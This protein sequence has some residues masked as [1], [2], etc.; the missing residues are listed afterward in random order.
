MLR[1]RSSREG[2][3]HSSTKQEPGV[4]PRRVYRVAAV[5]VATAALAACSRHFPTGGGYEMVGQPY[6]VNGHRYV[7]RE[8][9]NYSRVGYASWYGADF[10]GH[11]TANGE[12]YDMNRITAAHTTLPLP[13]YVRVTNLENNS[14]IVVRVND[15]GPFH[16]GRIIDLSAHAADLLG[17]KTAGIARVRVEYVGPA[18]LDGNDERML[19]ATYQAPGDRAMRIAYDPDTRTVSATS[20]GIFTRIAQNQN[21]D[22]TP[23]VY[24]PTAI[25]EGED[26]LAGLLGYAGMPALTPAQQ[27]AEAAATGNLPAGSDPVVVQI[28]VFSDLE[29]AHRVVAALRAYGAPMVE[30]VDGAAGPMFSVRLTTTAD[31]AQ[32]SIDA[33]A[34]VG[35]D[36]AYVV[37]G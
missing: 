5:L 15:R 23:P 19:M 16:D 37:P 20:G 31:Q 33:A 12:I 29:Q 22:D 2:R 25:A 24:T 7:P 32:A 36:G 8:D 11:T 30:A 10:H 13:S 1:I 6:V 26:P 3:V 27:A 9:P 17:M 28:G 14:S 4:R 18:S 35:A 21:Q 34:A